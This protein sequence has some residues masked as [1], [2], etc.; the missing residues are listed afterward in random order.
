[1]LSL[2]ASPHA[3][4]HD[5]GNLKKL[6]EEGRLS[7]GG[8][9]PETPDA[10]FASIHQMVDGRRKAILD[11]MAALAREYP[12][13]RFAELGFDF[14]ATRIPNAFA[15]HASEDNS[16]AIGLD[17]TLHEMFTWLVLAAQWTFRRGQTDAFVQ[18][19]VDFVRLSFLNLPAPPEK[20]AVYSQFVKVMLKEN[21]AVGLGDWVLAILARF[22]VAHEMG[23]VYL[24]HFN[25]GRA[26]KMRFVPASGR[27]DE[28]SGFDTEDEY[29][30]DDW[31]AKGVLQ[32]A[33]TGVVENLVARTAPAVFF[34]ILA[35]VE[36]L[37]RP[38]TALGAHMRRTHP[39]AAE[40]A[41]ALRRIGVL[42]KPIPLPEELS[43]LFA[44]PELISSQRA[45]PRFQKLA[46]MHRE[47]YAGLWASGAVA[48]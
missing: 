45:T 24:G 25:K 14:I 33:K 1:M 11:F 21:E 30:A 19:V 5:E 37:C 34:S 39:P 28:V 2:R 42:Q 6:I 13:V 31:A 9:P 36:D 8:V 44:L 20:R 41:A 32:L 16:Y 17:P 43:I 35:M 26:K 12:N 27:E 22:L 4:L 38:T 10:L 3:L 23:H 18:L 48:D 46:R 40:R 15:I 47:H 29:Q 7:P